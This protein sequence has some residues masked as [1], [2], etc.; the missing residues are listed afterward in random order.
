MKASASV[1]FNSTALS[2]TSDLSAFIRYNVNGQAIY[3]KGTEGGEFY[4]TQM[5]VWNGCGVWLAGSFSDSLVS[6]IHRVMVCGH[7]ALLIRESE[8]AT[9]LPRLADVRWFVLF[10]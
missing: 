1:E 2:G 7:I 5:A 6:D 10:I 9:P 8:W 4:W 3:I